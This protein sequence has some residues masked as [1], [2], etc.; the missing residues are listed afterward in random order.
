[1]LLTVYDAVSA[2]ANE[3]SDIKQ[4]LLRSFAAEPRVYPTADELSPGCNLAQGWMPSELTF[5]FKT[6]ASWQVSL[7]TENHNHVLLV[8]I[9]FFD[10]GNRNHN[11]GYRE[12]LCQP[13]TQQKFLWCVILSESHC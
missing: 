2:T 12:P 1:M 10:V 3:H 4:Q 8:V 9:A 6:L 13:S 11:L 7:T 5:S